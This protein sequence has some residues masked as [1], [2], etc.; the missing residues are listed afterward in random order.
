MDTLEQNRQHVLQQIRLAETAAQRIAGSVQLIAVS[1]TFPASDIRLLYQHG[2]RAF[3]ENYIQEFQQKQYDLA[4]CPHIEWHIIGHV[5]SNKTRPVAEHAHWLHTVS[6]LKTAQRLSQ[7]RPKHLPPL[8]ICMEINISGET[9]KHGIAP[10]EMLPLAQ[11][12]VALPHLNLRGLMCVASANASDEIL[13]QQF[14]KMA[15]LLRDL[16]NIAP[17]ADTLSMGMSGDMAVAI[18]CGANMVR[19]G[20][21][22]FGRRAV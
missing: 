4:D 1:K 19:V 22:I 9:A 16:Q 21:A 5:Q 12:I 20:S 17:Q 3:G 2:Q 8:Q 11:A 18:E 15:D 14:E 13:R 6:S 10:D 7:Q